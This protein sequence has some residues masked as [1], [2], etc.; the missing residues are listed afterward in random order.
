VGNGSPR[1]LSQLV[2]RTVVAVLVALAFAPT[3]LAEDSTLGVSATGGSVPVTV[4]ASVDTAGPPSVQASVST[5][6]PSAP[7]ATPVA[8]PHTRAAA[9]APQNSAAVTIDSDA[10]PVIE[11]PVRLDVATALQRPNSRV[12]SPKSR[13]PSRDAT[14]VAKRSGFGR[15]SRNASR[16]TSS[17]EGG[18]AIALPPSPPVQ[19]FL[20][21]AL[22]TQTTSS[23]LKAPGFP[24]PSTPTTGFGA[25]GPGGSGFG[26]GLLLFA[27]A[28]ELAVFG[29]PYLGRRVLPLLAAPRPHPYLLQLER[30]D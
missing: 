5:A 16:T 21:D 19:T 28:A 25:A 24:A 4:T 30:P 15:S 1:L 22:R 29:L 14:D 8:K 13:T 18:S 9:R 7:L 11:A 27:L 6:Q 3:A 17:T 12:L 10:A 26:V 20:Q 2:H 23:G